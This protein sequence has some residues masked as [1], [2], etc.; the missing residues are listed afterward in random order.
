LEAKK[1]VLSFGKNYKAASHLQV[2]LPKDSFRHEKP[3]NE[4]AVFV[5]PGGF[6]LIVVDQLASVLANLCKFKLIVADQFSRV[7]QI[8]SPFPSEASNLF[9]VSKGSGEYF[10]TDM[11]Q[12]DSAS[13]QLPAGVVPAHRVTMDTCL[14]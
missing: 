14:P 9:S 3:I 10:S 8:K 13:W 11:V 5:N 6:K 2:K 7:Q 4:P 1:A 12:C